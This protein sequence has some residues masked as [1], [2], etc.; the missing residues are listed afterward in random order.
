[1]KVATPVDVW[2]LE[3]D[4]R[5]YDIANAQRGDSTTATVRSI[6]RRRNRVEVEWPSGVRTWVP[7]KRLAK[8]HP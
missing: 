5:V 6:Q 2:A 8:V 4:D 7:A 1:M 3:L